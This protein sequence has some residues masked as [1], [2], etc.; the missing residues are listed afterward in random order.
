M[1]S[2]RRGGER[3][4]SFLLLSSGFRI[5]SSAH[6]NA[7]YLGEYS[8]SF[9]ASWCPRDLSYELVSTSPRPPPSLE[10]V[11]PRFSC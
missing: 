4:P 11:H 8:S 1:S 5:S 9:R 10:L 2:S 7:V 6:T 3:L